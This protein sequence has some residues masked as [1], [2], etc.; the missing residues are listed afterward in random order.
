M[1]VLVLM[2]GGCVGQERREVPVA[3][4]PEAV[5]ADFAL[6]LTVY[7]PARLAEDVR[8]LP[9]ALRPARYVLEADHLLRVAI[10]SGAT[11]TTF[12]PATRQLDDEQVQRLW[13]LLRLSGVLDPDAT[14]AIANVETYMPRHDRT[15]A[16]M[17]VTNTGK[18]RAV[19]VVLDR[20]TRQ[21][22][23][24]EQL[25]DKLAELAWQ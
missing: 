10:G 20:S 15:T 17:S 25:T 11:P 23:L 1:I 18:R 12:P 16:V 7:S 9:R 5:P 21:A 13:S 2:L 6:G 22:I 14:V 3:D 19:R 8:S 24:I 4:V